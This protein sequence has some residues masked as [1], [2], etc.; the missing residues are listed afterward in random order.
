MK[1]KILFEAGST[2]TTVLSSYSL[3][4][5]EADLRQS[6]PIQI[7]L[8]GYNPNRPSTAF[9]NELKKLT[10]G[11]EDEIYF[12]G[13][14][15]NSSANKVKVSRLF[16]DLFGAKV[17]VFDDVIGAA[18][19]AYSNQEGIVGILGTG[20]V[21]AVY[22]GQS[23]QEIRG[24]WGYLIDDLGGGYEL[25]KVTLSAWLNQ[26]LSDDL[27]REIAEYVGCQ[28]EE[29]VHHYYTNPQLGAQ[30]EGLKMVA[31]VVTF[32]SKYQ[33]NSKE[34]KII[35]DYFKLFFNR[36]VSQIS[37]V[38]QIKNVRF[39]G[40]VAAAFEPI[41]RIITQENGMVMNEIVQFPAQKLWVFHFNLS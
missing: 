18:R 11:T 30:S 27:A 32:L 24:G 19:A 9:E 10:I 2:K 16:E 34:N 26:S 14:G 33:G 25:G 35:S 12:Y 36:H 22:D 37:E 5:T 29:F 38:T 20:A 17:A 39:I 1:N 28:R 7:N 23:I 3:H 15:L 4:E 8:S 6:E 40:S 41:L 21:V 31:G 13:S